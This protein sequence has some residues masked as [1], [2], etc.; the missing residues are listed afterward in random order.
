VR[1]NMGGIAVSGEVWLHAAHLF[2]QL[3]ESCVQ[4]PGVEVLYRSCSRRGDCT[5]GVNQWAGAGRRATGGLDAFKEHCRQLM[6]EGA[7]KGCAEGIKKL[8]EVTTVS[9]ATMEER[10]EVVE[11]DLVN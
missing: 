2:V 7:A 3:S 10:G 8:K 9:V 11:D 4:S 1:S 6:A 5:G